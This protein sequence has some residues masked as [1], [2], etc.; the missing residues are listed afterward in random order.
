[1]QKYDKLDVTPINDYLK[2]HLPSRVLP[3]DEVVSY[4]NYGHALANLLVEEVTGTNFTNYTEE[5]V[6][7]PLGRKQLAG[8]I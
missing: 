1:M 2:T 8:I 4:S 6:L 5:E 7:R 3:P